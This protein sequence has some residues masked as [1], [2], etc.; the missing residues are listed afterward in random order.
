M[1]W[2]ISKYLIYLIAIAGALYIGAL[3]YVLSFSIKPNIPEHA[4][5]ILILGAKVNLDN[6]PSDPLYERTNEAV[7]LYAQNKADYIITT[8]GVGLGSAPEASISALVAQEKGVPKDK[9]LTDKNS[10]NTFQNVDEGKKIA[11]EY[12]IKSVI[13]IS[14]RYHVARGVLFARHLGF[15]PVYW[16]YP[17]FG[18]YK[19]EL[20]IQN[21]A[22]EALA[23]LFYLPKIYLTK[24]LY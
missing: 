17:D 22:R 21:Y 16:D 9:I 2:K 14:D 13:V 7:K 15:N 8:G 3:V 6:S 5:A 10:H 20:L 12:N 1:F 23:I 19:K 11:N 24:A 4:D 18:Y